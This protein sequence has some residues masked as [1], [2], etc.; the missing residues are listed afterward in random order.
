MVLQK[1][2]LKTDAARRQLNPHGTAEFPCAAYLCCLSDLPRDAIIWHRHEKLEIIYI[3]EGTMRL[4]VPG[5][6][7][8]LEKGEVALINSD[9]LHYAIGDPFCELYSVVFSHGLISGGNATAF[10]SK[11]ICPLLAFPGFAVWRT[12]RQDLAEVFQAAFSA[13]ETDAFAYEFTVRE[14]F[15]E[16]LLSCFQSFAPQLPTQR[17]E[18][19]TDT[20][21]IE[22]MLEYI[23]THYFEP[24]RLSDIAQAADLSER[25]CLRCF[26]RT[27]GD[28]PVQYLLKHRLLR[29]AAM[30]HSMPSASIA[31]ISAKCGFDHPSYY[32]KQFRRFYQCAPRDYRSQH[33]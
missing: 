7:Y 17:P 31:E 25:E 26:N 1:C 10:Y 15:S 32:T 22:K 23:H 12:D 6:E 29:S 13:L 14:R 19:N 20:V 4:L 30:L 3:Q 33:N 5:E 21:R 24:L 28:T 2:G 11:Y 8:R 9:I 27:I 18:K 16:I